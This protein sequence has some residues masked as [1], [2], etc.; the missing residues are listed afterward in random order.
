MSQSDLALVRDTYK[1]AIIH[2]SKMAEDHH[3]QVDKLKREKIQR[4]SGVSST[5]PSLV[6]ELLESIQLNAD[7]YV[8]L[9]NV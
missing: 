9:Q 1:A 7:L 8:Q 3:H 4:S 6:S 5:S 2:K